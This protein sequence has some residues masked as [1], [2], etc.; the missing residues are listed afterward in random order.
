MW[1]GIRSIIQ[2]SISVC[3]RATAM[4]HHSED[5]SIVG[6]VVESAVSTVDEPQNDLTRLFTSDEWA[7]LRKLRVSSFWI[8][9]R[10]TA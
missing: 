6:S 4:K 3:L 8:T 9:E 1:A 10:F 5:V 7:A 2:P